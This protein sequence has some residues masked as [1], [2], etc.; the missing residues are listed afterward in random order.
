MSSISSNISIADLIVSCI[1]SHKGAA[2]KSK[3]S[4]K[5]K[6]SCLKNLEPSQISS[7]PTPNIICIPTLCC[8]VVSW[9]ACAKSLTKCSYKLIKEHE[10]VIQQKYDVI[11]ALMLDVGLRGLTPSK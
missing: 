3:Y 6:A 9:K 10:L 5:R 8:K 7:T 1:N 4:A 11:Q 2:N